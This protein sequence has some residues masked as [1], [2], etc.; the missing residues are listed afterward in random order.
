MKI[1][2]VG[3]SGISPKS[4]DIRETFVYEVASRLIKRYGYEVTVI[5]DKDFQTQNGASE[6]DGIRLIYSQYSKAKHALMFYRDSIYKARKS[7]DI[8][9][10]FG[11]WGGVH[12]FLVPHN[13]ALITN[14]DRILYKN[15]DA[16]WAIHAIL[17]LF[18]R[19]SS[20]QSDLLLCN[21][22]SL[23]QYMI[24]HYAP[25][26]TKVIEYGTHINAY[27]DQENHKVQTLLKH[28]NLIKKSYHLVVGSFKSQNSIDTIIQ[29]YQRS[30]RLY[31]LVLVG[32]VRQKLYYKKLTKL[33]NLSVIFIE[34]IHDQDAIDILRANAASVIHG[35]T[36][37]NN[38][39]TLLAA[40]AS[41]NIILAHN[42]PFNKEFLGTY[43]LYWRSPNE[44]NRLINKIEES[45]L[46]YKAYI[47]HNYKRIITYYNW[48]DIAKRYSK[49]FKDTLRR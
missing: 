46:R 23:E 14:I 11:F 7:S 45:P 25:K 27:V 20:K 36:L 15:I 18:Y 13:I 4:I 26:N 41:K 1:A 39:H 2:F 32:E 31:P 30:S 44:L 24:E 8:I 35:D 43:G 29:G 34:N 19:L 42:N 33:A 49:L 38:S 16:S 6:L 40:M 9:Y 5:C 37:G 3:I 12:S 17:R 22:Y 21:S 48:R 10:A 47:E 28:H